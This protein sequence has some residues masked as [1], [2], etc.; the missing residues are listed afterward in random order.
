MVTTFVLKHLCG[1]HVSQPRVG[2]IFR[3]VLG[4][5]SRLVGGQ[6]LL[7]WLQWHLLHQWLIRPEDWPSLC[8]F[9]HCSCAF[10][11]KKSIP[12]LVVKQSLWFYL[13]IF[14]FL[15]PLA[16]GWDE[17]QDTSKA[18]LQ[19]SNQMFQ[20]RMTCAFDRDCRGSTERERKAA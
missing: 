8:I 3:L 10:F 4:S 13:Q 18:S 5:C 2:R 12:S 1:R 17:Y 6:S 20:K 14:F 11:F 7:A 9:P 15:N 19:K 16:P